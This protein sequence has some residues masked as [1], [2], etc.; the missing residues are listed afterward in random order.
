[1]LEIVANTL[2][3]QENYEYFGQAMYDIMTMLIERKTEKISKF[4][5]IQVKKSSLSYIIEYE[6]LLR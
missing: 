3:C 1:M 5:F 2:N 6:K 4:I